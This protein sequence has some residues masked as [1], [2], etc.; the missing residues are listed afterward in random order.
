MDSFTPPKGLTMLTNDLKSERLTYSSM[1]QNIKELTNQF[2][3]LWYECDTA[4]PDL[5]VSYTP[6]Q[7]AAMEKDLKRL[8]DNLF[9]ELRHPPQTDLERLSIQRR[10]STTIETFV[11]S[12]FGVEKDSINTIRT[13]G[14]A[15]IVSDFAGKARQFAPQ[16]TNEDIF[17]ASRNVWSMNIMQ[18]LMGLP[19][20]MTP[21]IFAYSMLYPLTDNYLDD[22]AITI[23]TKKAFSRRFQ[24][25]LAGEEIL[26]ANAYERAICE[27]VGMIENQFDRQRYA[28]VYNS[29]QAIHSA[30]TKSLNLLNKGASPYELDVL[31]ICFEKGGTS[32]LADGCL[33]AGSLNPNQSEFMF[34]YGAF[35]QMMDDLEDVQQDLHNGLETIFSQTARNWPL[36]AVTNRTFHFG[37]R[38]LRALDGFAAPGAELLTDLL[39]RSFNPLLIASAG[40][41]SRLYTRPYLHQIESYL[42]VRFA[43]LLDQRRRLER[44]HVS[45]ISLIEAFAV[46]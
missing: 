11:K 24:Q 41:S 38:L 35:T 36:D 45:A 7:Q 32:V 25:R 28:Q 37:D 34:F 31:G 3:D 43:F 18:A 30:Q 6:S 44:R 12:S 27:L 21:S 17:Q 15:E 5:G 42:P 29:L 20:Q 14:F 4:L 40:S 33:V 13:Y 2:R 10:I 26:P 16:I 46:H 22:Q 1:Q 39:R 19:V 9:G 8:L 23:E